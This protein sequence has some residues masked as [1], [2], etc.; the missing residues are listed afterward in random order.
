[1]KGF[2][3]DKYTNRYILNPPLKLIGAKTKI[4]PLLYQF[5]PE[6]NTYIEPFMG[7]AGV[8]IG[9]NPSTLETVSDLN[10]YLIN[11]YKTLQT[12]KEEFWRKYQLRLSWLLKK[13]KEEFESLKREIIFTESGV[14]SAV[15]LYLITKVC[16][17]GILRFNQKGE[18]NSSYC[19]QTTGRGFM[20]REYF[21]LLCDRI[22]KINF[23]N[24]D[25]TQVIR[26]AKDGDFIFLDPPYSQCKTTYNGI[27][28]EDIHFK[29]LY[30]EL[31][32]IGEMGV[33]WLLTINDNEFIRDL[34]KSYYMVAH[35]VS[36]SC[37]QTNAGRGKKP[38]LIVTNYEIKETAEKLGLKCLNF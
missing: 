15:C 24:S 29:Y 30:E 25:Y 6:H 35:D 22:S 11:F 7:T 12:D 21:D 33:N 2:T 3:K 13:G 31:G 36:Y 37:S 32:F 27:K 1:M 23:I 28:W 8:C 16:M 20:N 9:K 17:N 5:F 18:C 14:V 4:R 10:Y 38:E 26:Y 19:G 34:F